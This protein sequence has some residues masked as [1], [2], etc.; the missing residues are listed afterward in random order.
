MRIRGF[1]AVEGAGDGRDEHHDS[2]AGSDDRDPSGSATC[3]DESMLLQAESPPNR[4]C[5]GQAA[6]HNSTIH[7][8]HQAR[9]IAEYVAQK[10]QVPSSLRLS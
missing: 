9:M 8:R 5:I 1:A 10:L 6:F 4:Y 2:H 3:G 7:I